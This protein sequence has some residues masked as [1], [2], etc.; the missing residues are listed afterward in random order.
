MLMITGRSCADDNQHEVEASTSH[1]AKQ[2]SHLYSFSI[3][4]RT[5]G[6][7]FSGEDSMD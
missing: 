5:M 6:G 7:D 2:S 3:D 1:G 4:P